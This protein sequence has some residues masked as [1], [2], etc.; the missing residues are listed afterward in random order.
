VKLR[1]LYIITPSRKSNKLLYPVEQTVYFFL[2]NDPLGW[3]SKRYF[4]SER[5]QLETRPKQSYQ[6]NK[7]SPLEQAK[8]NQRGSSYIAL[9][10]L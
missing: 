1:R 8:K 3:R 10:F 7:A 5:A 4:F 9:L 6:E 2:C